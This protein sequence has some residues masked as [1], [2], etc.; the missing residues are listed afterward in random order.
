MLNPL[1]PL[2]N[3]MHK[4]ISVTIGGQ[5]FY[6]EEDAYQ[7]L[8]EYLDSIKR[9]F[10]SYK[11]QEEIISD[12]EGRIAEKL[13]AQI[14]S[15]KQAIVASDVTAVIT[16]MGTVADF[17]EYADAP[18]YTDT[19]AYDALPSEGRKKLYRDMDNA[20]LGGVCS[21]IAAYFG[22]DPLFIRLLVILS[23]FA[24]GAGVVIYL[25]L[26]III[27]EAKTE[28]Q[29]SEMRG[30]NVT[31]KH[32]E[33]DVRDR[34]SHIDTAK[35]NA[36][37]QTAL[38]KPAQAANKLVDFLRELVNKFI[39]LIR[40]LFRIIFGIIGFSL[41]MAGAIGIAAAA[42]AVVTAIVNGGSPYVDFPYN[43]LFTGAMRYIAFAS[44]FIIIAVPLKLILLIG[45]SLLSA[46]RVI[47]VPSVVI[48]LSV[49]VIGL[50]AAG[51]VALNKAPEIR[52]RYDEISSGQSII[53]RDVTDLVDF[54]DIRVGGATTVVA[55][56]GDV[57][58][59]SISGTER[60]LDRSRASVRDGVLSVDQDND[61]RICLFCIQKPASLNVVAPTMQSINLSGASRAAISGFSGESFKATLSGAS[62]LELSGEFASTTLSMSG[63]SRAYLS[64]FSSALFAKLSGASYIYAFGMPVATASVGAS[65]ASRAE[66]AASSAIT[67]SL[68]GA[69]KVYY[70]GDAVLFERSVSGGSKVMREME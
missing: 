34:L 50:V 3:Y 33:Q 44:L 47:R 60:D 55:T 32:I 15:K 58:S 11:D 38:K 12:I 1:T 5:I 27:P 8:S 26:W 21:G 4:A 18:D 28:A 52:A 10:G 6:I 23:L 68:S 20:M 22:I 63:A 61:F 29:K 7:K 48:L 66:I 35:I 69:S 37:A 40:V 19:P 53:S 42:F 64:G 24:G 49:W 39:P 70:K 51:T 13:S 36:A 43:D 59:V 65:G 31:L 9:H 41:I 46:K 14:S 57:Y 62:R 16:S 17:A 56:Q 54:N 45:A 2:R 25:I 67:T 30:T